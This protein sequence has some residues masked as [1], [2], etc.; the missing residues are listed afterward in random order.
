MF[1]KSC[2]NPNNWGNYEYGSEIRSFTEAS[3]YS[4]TMALGEYPTCNESIS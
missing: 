4:N 2:G 1:E 3:S